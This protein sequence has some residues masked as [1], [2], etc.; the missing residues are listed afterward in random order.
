MKNHFLGFGFLFFCTILPPHTGWGQKQ[1]AV[2]VAAA[3]D[4]KFALDSIIEV[5]TQKSG[6]N[7]EAIYGSSGKL[8]EQISNKAPFH[9]F[10]SADVHYPQMLKDRG[11]TGSDIYIYGKGRIVLWSKKINTKEKG[12]S[13]LTDPEIRKLAIANPRHAPYGKRAEEMLK[14]HQ[15]YEPL[16]KKL[17]YGEN[18]TQTAQFV[19]TGA[20]DIGIIALSLALA[21]TMQRQQPDYFL[22]PEDSH[23][24]LFQGAVI[25]SHG[26]GKQA[27]TDFF[28]FL[29]SD[30]ALKILQFYGFSEP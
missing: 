29:K 5:Y 15:L 4:L 21:P 7:V 9:V 14:H 10:M 11:L 26:K 3:S 30:K 6:N 8:F 1:S 2:L 12:L 20:A 17:V 19:S 16:Q 28:G 23:D 25:T 27:V 13:G 18:I 24:P 22:I